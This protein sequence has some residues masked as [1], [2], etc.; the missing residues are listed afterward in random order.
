MLDITRYFAALLLVLGLLALFAFVLRRAGL[1]SALPSFQRSGAPRRIEVTA[2]VLLD[3][4]RRVVTVRVDEEEHV[5]LLG[6][7]G[8][9]VLDRRPA[10][11]RFEPVVPGDAAEDGGA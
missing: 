8:E 5:I 6:M 7:A 11:P 3:A 2:S 4:R 10:P 1:V 9:T